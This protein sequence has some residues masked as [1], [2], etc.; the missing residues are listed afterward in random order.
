MK[1]I[2]GTEYGQLSL[3]SLDRNQRDALLACGGN[4]SI[5]PERG[6]DDLWCVRAG[7][8]VGTVVAPG[9]TFRIRPKL[10]IARLFVMM[11]AASGSIRWNDRTIGLAESS[12]MED[13]V[14]SVLVDSIRRGLATGLLRGYVAVEE[15]SFVVRG[16]LELAKTL[17]RRPATLA[18]LVQTPEF[19]DENTPENR[20]LA[21]ALGHLASRV[22]SSLVRGRVVDCQRTFADVSVVPRGVPLPRVTRNRLNARWWGAIEL[23]MLVLQS[24]GLDLPS[25]SHASRS[26][27]VDMNAVFERFVHHALADE[28]RHLGHD[29]QHNRGGI[30]LDTDGRHTLRP[31]LSIWSGTK[32][33]YAGDCKYKYAA[34]GAARRDDLYQCLA[35]S[36]AT[37]LS[38]I[39]LIY[40]GGPPL[41]RDVSIVDGRTTVLVRT[42]DLGAATE[43][44]RGQFASLAREIARG[45]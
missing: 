31:D 21:T 33:V 8:H 35:Y 20:I 4:F 13:V 39:T 43:E 6:S 36:A 34:D 16:R 40:G 32:C 17:R 9:M 44:L 15:E 37:G 28:L 41:A 45:L 10:S 27:L 42:L 14:A 26:F 22:Q 2:E 1:Q 7:S 30:N 3:L 38:R 5:S 11:S 12:A 24:C 18:P 29:L 19:L 25:G 23:A